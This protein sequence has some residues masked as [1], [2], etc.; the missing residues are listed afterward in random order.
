MACSRGTC[1]RWVKPAASLKPV[2]LLALAAGAV[3]VFPLGKTGGLI[4]AMSAL[5]V[6]TSG[7]RFPLGKTGGLIEA[8][9]FSSTSTHSKP[10]FPLGKT[11]GLIEAF[12]GRSCPDG[13]IPV[14]AG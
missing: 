12:G 7:Y 6:V 11:G 4:E 9:L 1:F 13:S 8:V 3:S 2:V 5:G 14:S 10:V